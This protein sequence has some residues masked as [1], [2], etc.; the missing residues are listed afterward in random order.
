V[1]DRKNTALLV[2]RNVHVRKNTALLVSRNVQ[3]RKNTRFSSEPVYY[4]TAM[5]QAI[6]II[7]LNAMPNGGAAQKY[8]EGV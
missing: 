4:L 8:M 3:E 7:I 6:C 1:Q 5:L 2:F